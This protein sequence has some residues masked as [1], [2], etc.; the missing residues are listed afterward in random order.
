[1]K[2]LRKEKINLPG[3]YN[4]DADVSELLGRIA[5]QN[6][7]VF[8][9]KKGLQEFVKISNHSHIHKHYCFNLITALKKMLMK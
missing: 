5:C 6:I 2:I 4:L 3:D 8:A 7:S 9:M 1:L